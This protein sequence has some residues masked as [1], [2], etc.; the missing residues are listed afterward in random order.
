MKTII[1]IIGIIFVYIIFFDTITM[2]TITPT[3]PSLFFQF[4]IM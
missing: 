2:T 4:C 1:M 3:L